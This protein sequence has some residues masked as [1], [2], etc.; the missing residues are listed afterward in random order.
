MRVFNLFGKTG[1][2]DAIVTAMGCAFCFPALG[3]LSAAV[4]LGFL[5]QFVGVFINT[6]L[7]VFAA[8]A[9]A[10]NLLAWLSHRRSLCLLAGTAGPSITSELTVGAATYCSMRGLQ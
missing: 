5:A 4:A 6:L 7:P 8:T 9:L 3:A 2:L 1:A 10:A